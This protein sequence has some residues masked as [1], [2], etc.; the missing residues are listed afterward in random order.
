[1]SWIKERIKNWLDIK[2]APA[3][4][5]TIQDAYSHEAIVLRNQLWY[6]G[7]ASELD[8]FF[9]QTDDMVG[10]SNFW[11]ARGTTGINIRK[12][13]SGLPAL[14]VD[15]LA[16][17]VVRDLNG[18]EIDT[19]EAAE[20]WEAIG[21]ENKFDEML[22]YVIVDTLVGGDGAFKLSYDSVLSQYPI[23]EFF[24]G[25]RVKYKY[26]RGRLE[27][28]SF[29]SEKNA[30]NKKYILEEE[31]SPNG[32]QYILYDNKGDEVPVSTIPELVDLEN[33]INPAGFMMAIQIMFDKSPNFNGRGKGILQSKTD[34]FDAF[35]ECISQW[36]E[37]MRDGRTHKYIPDNMLPKNSFNGQLLKP[38]AFDNRY[39]QTASDMRETAK[40]EI[41][42]TH[43]DI[44]SDS[45]AETYGTLLD[46]CLQGIISPSTLGIDVKKLDN[47]ESQREKEKATLYTRNKIIE[48]L[49]KVI[50]ALIDTVLKMDDML[51]ER[52]PQEYEASVSFGEYAN[53]SFEAQVETLG[54]AKA[55]GIMSIPRVVNELYGDTLTEEEKEEEINRL[56]EEQGVIPFPVNPEA[57]HEIDEL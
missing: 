25:S 29:I 44:P 2:E 55:F 12:I 17:I 34:S 38:N 21:A 41:T 36:V 19:P 13:H 56:N 47:A 54:K 30:G 49:E 6:R 52:I 7:E 26:N 24:S 57:E 14:I 37:S 53:P 51:H 48:K 31:Y 33:V 23:I 43:G 10:N 1:M 16:S 22:Q 20:R 46:L 28:I 50:P 5:A 27:T 35:D 18:I 9:S 42:V 32:I 8:Q 15:T 45:L 3:L 39:I 11:A 4:M 40:N